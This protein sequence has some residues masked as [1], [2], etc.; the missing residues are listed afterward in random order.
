MIDIIILLVALGLMAGLLIAEKRESPRSILLFKT[1]LS[2][3]FVAVALI[4]PHPDQSYYHWILAGLVWGLIGDVCLALPGNKAFKAG[5]VAFLVGHILYIVA[6]ARLSEPAA[7]VTPAHLLIAAASVGVFWW[8]RPHLG[9]ML[10]PVLFY[11]IVI[12]V[13]LAAAWVAFLNP[14]VKAGGAWTLLIGALCFYF[15]DV[16]VARDRFVKNQFANRL[17]GLPLYYAGQ[18]LLAFSVG[19]IR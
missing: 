2:V 9:A 8:L 7:W 14:A 11:V 3:L 17:L 10:V 15:S 4:Q 19:L 1:P 6:F 16:F 18:F 5:L 12:S 13:M